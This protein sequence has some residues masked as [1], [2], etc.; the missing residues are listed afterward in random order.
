MSD[1]FVG[2]LHKKNNFL[3][4]KISTH[5]VLN[6]SGI[7]LTSESIKKIL[8]DTRQTLQTVHFFSRLILP[9]I[10]GLKSRL[11]QKDKEICALKQAAKVNN[12]TKYVFVR[13]FQY[14]NLKLFQYTLHVWEK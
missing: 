3:P 8:D 6:S 1:D 7:V 10:K 4:E 14:N 9:T 11:E 12:K 13:E 2:T 5:Y